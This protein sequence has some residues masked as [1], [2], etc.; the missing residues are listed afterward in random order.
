MKDDIIM[1]ARELLMV[2]SV[3]TVDEFEKIMRRINRAVSTLYYQS[4]EQRTMG[5]CHL[6]WAIMSH[7]NG[8]ALDNMNRSYAFHVLQNADTWR[9]PVKV[10][11]SGKTGAQLYHEAIKTQDTLKVMWLEGAY[12]EARWDYI[13]WIAEQET[14]VNSEQDMTLRAYFERFATTFSSLAPCD[15]SLGA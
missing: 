9:Y 10:K 11:N 7:D 5:F 2:R 14:S 6:V 13:E 8:P 1:L 4:E 3:N 15:Y 12:A